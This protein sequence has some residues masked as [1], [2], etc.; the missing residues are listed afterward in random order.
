MSWMWQS[1]FIV[2]VLATCRRLSMHAKLCSN[3]N[4]LFVFF[5]SVKNTKKVRVHIKKH[6]SISYVIM[7]IR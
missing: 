5:I 7:I 1:E 2:D 3:I 4:M 6:T